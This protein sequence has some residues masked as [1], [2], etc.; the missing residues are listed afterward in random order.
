MIGTRSVPH[1]IGELSPTTRSTACVAVAHSG[2][3]PTRSV[4]SGPVNL[5]SAE[6]KGVMVQG[7][8][9]LQSAVVRWADSSSLWGWFSSV[10]AGA[11]IS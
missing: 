4:V 9:V 7:P 11:R 8:G 1:W 10:W 3:E 5:M 2:T 6:A